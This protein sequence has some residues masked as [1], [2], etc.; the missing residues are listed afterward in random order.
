MSGFATSISPFL[1]KDSVSFSAKT[2]TPC[3]AYWLGLGI[4]T[5][6]V[7]GDIFLSNDEAY[8]CTQGC[9][10]AS[11]SVARVSGL[12][13]SRRVISAK[14]IDDQHLEIEMGIAEPTENV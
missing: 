14:I 13:S 4:T 7:S 5:S 6:F 12:I 8:R 2:A 9:E 3:V 1:Y 11:A 10:N